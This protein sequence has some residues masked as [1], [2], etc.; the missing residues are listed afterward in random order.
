[1]WFW[2]NIYCLEGC[3]D[4]ARKR[5]SQESNRRY[6]KSHRG[7]LNAARRQAN[8]RKRQR[9]KLPSLSEFG[10]IV[11]FQDSELAEAGL[12]I[13]EPLGYRKIVHDQILLAVN[14][15]AVSEPD[16]EGVFRDIP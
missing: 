7:R 6:Q 12:F 10:K 1:M 13:E 16:R 14:D 2:Q 9:Q 8:Y 4:R 11:T 15:R 5:K 3:A